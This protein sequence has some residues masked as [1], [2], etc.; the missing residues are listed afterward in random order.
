MK[1]APYFDVFEDLEIHTHDLKIDEEGLT[2]NNFIFDD[3]LF[4]NLSVFGTYTDSSQKNLQ[5]ELDVIIRSPFTTLSLP[6]LNGTFIVKVNTPRP[7][8]HTY[9]KLAQY[10]FKIL[11]EFANEKQLIDANGNLFTVP[12]FLYGQSHFSGAIQP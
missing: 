8:G 2:N 12:P 1:M 9:T 6:L 3:N 7:P 5:I 11:K 10:A 4:T